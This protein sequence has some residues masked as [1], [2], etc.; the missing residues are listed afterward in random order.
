[1]KKIDI[2]LIRKYVNGEDLGEYSIEQLENDKDFMMGVISYT[3]DTKMYSSC[4]ELVKQDY[5]FVKYL[6]LKFKDNS[7]F[8]TAV[9]DNYLDNT[10]TDWERRELNIIMEKVL[11]KEL[12]AELFPHVEAVYADVFKVF[13]IGFIPSTFLAID[14]VFAAFDATSVEPVLF[15]VS[16]LLEVV[17]VT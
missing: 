3:N 17:F 6:V 11:P 16:P 8:I 5:E 15:T 14:D 7:E 9:A 12:S 2:S 13:T 10:D 1:M 4:S